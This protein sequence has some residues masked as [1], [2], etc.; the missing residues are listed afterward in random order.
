MPREGPGRATPSAEALL[1]ELRKLTSETAHVVRRIHP[2]VAA[3]IALIVVALVGSS[4]WLWYRNARITRART[5]LIPEITRLAET[6]TFRAW[7][8]FKEADGS[9]RGSAARVAAIVR[10]LTREGRE[11][12]GRGARVHCAVRRRRGMGGNRNHAVRIRCAVRRV[13]LE[14]RKGRIRRRGNG[15]GAEARTD[16][17]REAARVGGDARWHGVRF[18]RR[19]RS[20]QR[21]AVQL[22][23]Y[24]LDRYEVN[25]RQFKAFVDAGGYRRSGYAAFHRHNRA[26]GA[27]R[28]ELG[29]FPSGTA[30]HP[31]SGIGWFEALAYLRFSRKNA[32][33]GAH[34]FKASGAGNFT[35]I[36]QESNF[37][38]APAPV[39]TYGGL[40]PFGTYDMAGNVKEWASN[41]DGDRRI[42]RRGW[43]EPAYLFHDHDARPAADA[44][45]RM[46]SAAAAPRRRRRAA[47]AHRGA[48]R[49][50]LLEAA[51]G[52]SAGRRRLPA[53]VRLRQAAARHAHRGGNV[54]RPMAPQTISIMSPAGERMRIRVYLP[55][56]GKPPYQTVIFFP[57]SYMS[58]MS[59]P[60]AFIDEWFFDFIMRSGR[61]V[62]Y[63]TYEG[64][65]ERRI[66]G[67]RR[68]TN[69]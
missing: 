62:V 38:P 50:R 63:P 36:L 53:P 61:A 12:T 4:A 24:W 47:R 33:D 65:F 28:M 56:R 16:R 2:A 44:P 52:A 22:G 5:Y 27:G 37:G 42:S 20:S 67:V 68:G 48:V 8:V 18:R 7:K 40:G 69:Q 46:A 29:A 58:E 1:S 39:G 26:S 17:S 64:D 60:A 21:P 59:N 55:S 49:A 14:V 23:D 15:A 66:A 11:R 45:R 43:S 6:D 51:A 41:A 25:N 10:Q 57:G 9:D 31:V 30:D 13:A 35:R 19:L 3:T 34:W 54:A 32:A